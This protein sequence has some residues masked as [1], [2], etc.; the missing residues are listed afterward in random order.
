MLSPFHVSPSETSLFHS[1][2]SSCLYEGAPPPTHSCLPAMPFLY[3]GALSTSGP[4]ASPTDVQQGHPLLHMLPEPWVPPCV[5]FG[6]LS[7]PQELLGFWP[8]DTVAPSMG[9]QIPTVPSVPFPSSLSGTLY[10]PMVGSEDL[11]LYLSGPGRASQETDI[12]LQSAN[13]S[14]HPQK[15]SGLVTVYGMDLQVE[16]SW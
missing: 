10:I 2:P 13:T 1:P 15:H 14:W 3:T 6:C 16:Q 11:L 4:R 7:S 12:R 5:L 8:V 9:L